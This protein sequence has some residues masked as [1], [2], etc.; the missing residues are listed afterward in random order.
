MKIQ[1]MQKILAVTSLV[2]LAA[3]GGGGGT[4]PAPSAS[5][6]GAITSRIV[7]LGDSLTAG[8][9]AGGFL[10][11]AVPPV[12]NP[13]V[14]APVPIVPAGQE[15]GWW[16]LLYQQANGLTWASQ[17]NP[18]TSVLPLIAGPGLANQLVTAGP[19]SP[20]PFA[21]SKASG[22]Q[23]NDVAGFSPSL[24]T[25]T[26][27]NPTG[28]NYDL[29]VPGIT[30]HETIAMNQPLAPTCAPI[31]GVPP[32]LAGLLDVVNGESSLFYPVLGQFQS[33]LG[34]NLTELNAAV[35]LKPTLTTVWLG[36]NDL[37][38]FTFSGGQFCLG[39][40]THLVGGVCAIDTTGAQVQ[41]DMTTII[42]ALQKAGSKV[43]VANLPN[44][45]QEPQFA[46]VATPPAPAACVVQTYL[47]CV[48]QSVLT[49][50]LIAKGD[51]NAVADAQAA[52]AGIT[53]Y[54][55]A[56][57]KLAP[58][59]YVNETGAITALEQALNPA[60][61]QITL[62]NI[63]LDPNGPGSGL[64]TFYLTPAFAATVLSYNQTI[65]NGIAAAARALN[66]PVVPIFDIISGIASGSGPNFLAAASINPAPN[67]R[68]GAPFTCC[69][70]AF[71]F[72]LLS[73]D[74]IHPSNTGYALIA[75]AF[76]QTIDSAYGATI[77]PVNPQAVYQGTGA[78]AG[79]PDPYAFH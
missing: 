6:A 51:P 38:K 16:S 54:V 44:V 32:A 40:S 29:G 46:S 13:N 36:G 35:S 79:F 21:S 41:A 22:C 76:I 71:G 27:L 49:P 61:G 12:P 19:T 45:L 68:T 25:S 62:T 52:A 20:L 37:L 9:Q 48:Y 56:T 8:Y 30:I 18:A 64:G 74:G 3:C 28:T 69:S 63:N 26:R 58:N 11:Q 24:W 39:D 34:K 31:P 43:V 73:F 72:G 17:A 65:N 67:P 14:G 55:A 7:G 42:S 2:S 50:I 5:P 33:V 60:T 77:P 47:V 10:G 15:S 70:L 53:A 78:N 1:T 66:V 57:Y 59:G 75:N 4:V 23:S